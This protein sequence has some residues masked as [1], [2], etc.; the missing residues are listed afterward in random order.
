LYNANGVSLGYDDDDSSNGN[1]FLL[2]CDIE[3]ANVKYYL[4]IYHHP[5]YTGNAN[6]SFNIIKNSYTITYNANGGSVSPT[7]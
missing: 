2:D 5:N 3:T 7:S 1:N 6:I 4:K